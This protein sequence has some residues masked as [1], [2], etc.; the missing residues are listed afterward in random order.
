MDTRDPGMN[1]EALLIQTGDLNAW[2]F[3][4]L[5]GI[6]FDAEHPGFKN[7]VMRPHVIP[8]LTYAS[9]SLDSPQGKVTSRW[10]I[11]GGKCS[12][13][14]LVP[15]NATATVYVPS[16]RQEEVT[17]SGKPAASSAGVRFL[18]MENDSTVYEI[19]SGSY[20]F[21]SPEPKQ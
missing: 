19:G 2:F 11:Q 1:S 9:A 18:R 3:Q 7:V 6:D 12:W 13:N 10:Q 16:K 21:A 5:A 14:I 8:G 17:E 15:P 4:S 20:S